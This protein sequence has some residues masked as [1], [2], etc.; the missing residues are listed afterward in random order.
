M[1]KCH[2][3]S[4]SCRLVNP[5]HRCNYKT[6]DLFWWEFSLSRIFTDLIM[7]IY[8]S[9]QSALMTRCRTDF[10]HQYGILCGESQ[11]SFTRN[12]TRA[13]SKA[14]QLFSQANFKEARKGFLLLQCL[15]SN[16]RLQRKIFSG[17]GKLYFSLQLYS[18]A[19]IWGYLWCH[20]SYHGNAQGSQKRPI[21]FSF[22]N[23]LKN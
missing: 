23:Y 20:I 14:G 22:V 4:K 6:P 3:P 16:G 21:N 13:G 2:E 1:Y 18:W 11:T 12:A 5:N 7:H 9:N 8:W 15:W 17:V 19:I 10:R